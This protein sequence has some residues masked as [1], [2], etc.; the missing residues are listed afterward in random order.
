MQIISHFGPNY[1]GS[2]SLGSLVREAM[3][4]LR[5]SETPALIPL[6]R[7]AQGPESVLKFSITAEVFSRNSGKQ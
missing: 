7:I 4:S 2:E 5:D 1:T 3:S 6:T